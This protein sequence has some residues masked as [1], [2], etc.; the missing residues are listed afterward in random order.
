MIPASRVV[1]L[2]LT[3]CLLA[4][5][6][7][8][9]GAI[10][11]GD[12]V[13]AVLDRVRRAVGYERLRALAHGVEIRGPASL[14][15]APATHRQRFDATGRFH[16]RMDGLVTIESGFDGTTV[17]SRDLGG[18]IRTLALGER[19]QFMVGTM[20]QTH[21]WLSPA[22]PLAFRLLAGGAGGDASAS[23]VKLEF[24]LSDSPLSGVITV[25][26][27]SGRPTGVVFRWGAT[28]GT[29][30]MEGWAEHEG[31]WFPRHV[32]VVT[33]RGADASYEMESLAVLSASEGEGGGVFAP[34]EPDAGAARFDPGAPAAL[35][36]KRAPTGHMLVRARIN[37]GEE[38]WFI[39]D[40]GAGATVLATTTVERL[41]IATEGTLPALGVGGS[42]PTTLARPGSLTI[43]RLTME[44]PITIALDLAFLDAPMGEHIDGV[45]GFGVLHRSIARIDM[46]APS[47]ELHD[48]RTFD[49]AGLAW[50]RMELYN[51]VPTVEGAVEGHAGMFTLDTGA[52]G[53]SV[54]ICEPAVRRLNL[55][56]GRE[57]TASTA[58]GVG[59][60]IE[61]RAGKIRSLNLAG[62]E[63][64]GMDVVFVTEA[65]GAFADPYT[66]GNV[67]GQVL[68]PFTMY[69]D[70]QRRRIAL[71]PRDGSK[72]E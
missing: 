30:T 66:L 1:M 20:F 59:G 68:R 34:P 8:L 35:T 21:G 17:W 2:P 57:T 70:Y 26:A 45:I 56:E 25:D 24:E 33:A 14:L 11:P 36:I 12:G 69:T 62:A 65:K 23:G 49:G 53:S 37:G 61:A 67:G 15:G 72:N 18:E 47:V 19:D 10:P 3:T 64:G 16:R 38:G 28:E 60:F 6:P 39:F 22:A 48:P 55:L 4:G 43:G 32:S 50:A 52:G 71:I 31:M 7:A 58:G 40:T 9:A 46:A 5:T 13:G 51:R 54:A 42:V 41:K 44:R 27:E 29:I 63:L